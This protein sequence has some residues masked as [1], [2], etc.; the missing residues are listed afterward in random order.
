MNGKKLRQLVTST[1]LHW[2][3][4]V[5]LADACN[6]CAG[7]TSLLLP[8]TLSLVV[9]SVYT[10]LQQVVVVTV[11]FMASW[12]K[13]YCRLLNRLL[14]LPYPFHSTLI[15]RAPMCFPNLVPWFF[16]INKSK[17]CGMKWITVARFDKTFK[18]QF[19]RLRY[20][21]LNKTASKQCKCCLETIFVSRS[22]TSRP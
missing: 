18:D 15:H 12:N 14:F 2:K 8:V 21:A 17:H 7:L 9:H 3:E 16:E 1:R 4:S 5:K 11:V 10:E 19:W 20:N 6:A 13:L 22:E